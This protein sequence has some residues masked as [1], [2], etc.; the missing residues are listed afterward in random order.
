MA[1]DIKLHPVD[2]LFIDTLHVYGHL[3]R[4]LALHAPNVNKFIVMHDTFIDGP[5]N[6]SE[7]IRNQW[8]IPKMSEELGYSIEDLSTGLQPA[9]DEFIALHPNEWIVKRV[10]ENNNG[11]TILE[12]VGRK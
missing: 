7:A 1:N 9:I 2:L 5:A 10:Y 8:N 6:T 12:R 3:K 4:E 11:L